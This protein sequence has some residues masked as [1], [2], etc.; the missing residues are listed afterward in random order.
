M[1]LK[2]DSLI[3]QTLVKWSEAHIKVLPPDK[4]PGVGGL[5][6]N[7]LVLDLIFSFNYVYICVSEHGFVLEYR[8]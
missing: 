3:P 2:R 4:L 8:A 7:K 5:S 1:K 6:S